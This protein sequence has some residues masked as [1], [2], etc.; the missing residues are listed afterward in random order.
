MAMLAH[1]MKASYAFIERNFYLTR[2]SGFQQFGVHGALGWTYYPGLFAAPAD[3]CGAA[4]GLFLTGRVGLRGGGIN[5]SFLEE[6]T[7]AGLRLRSKKRSREA[8]WA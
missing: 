1:E 5:A 7:S 2:L 3:D 8:L 4:R 6:P